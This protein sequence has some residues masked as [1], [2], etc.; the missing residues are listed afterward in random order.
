MNE[1][2]YN[3]YQLSGFLDK[4][5]NWQIVLRTDNSKEMEN[6]LKKALPI[7]KKTLVLVD[8]VKGNDVKEVEVVCEVHNIE[9]KQY[10]SKKTGEPYWAHFAEFDGKRKACFGKGWI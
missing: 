1:K 9:M 7:I 4:D 10:T 6:A 5:R 3:K 2:Q 8:A